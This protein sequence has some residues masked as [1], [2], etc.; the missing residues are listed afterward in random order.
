MLHLRVRVQAQRAFQVN[1]N[2]IDLEENEFAGGFMLLFKNTVL[3]NVCADSQ[4]RDYLVD[5]FEKYK[6]NK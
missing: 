5:L 6:G 1:Q 3:I 2:I 4:D